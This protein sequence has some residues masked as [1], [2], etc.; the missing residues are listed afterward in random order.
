M[1]KY[2]PA[3]LAAMEAHFPASAPAGTV[4]LRLGE[5]GGA[6]ASPGVSLPGMLSFL[7]HGD[8]TKPVTG[9]DRIS[10]AGPAAG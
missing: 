9:L 5:R 10:A 6:V 8:T 1:S 2:Q 3:K 7:V 4:P